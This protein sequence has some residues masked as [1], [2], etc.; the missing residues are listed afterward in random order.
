MKDI[1]EQLVPAL[2]IFLFLTVLLGGAY[3]LLITAI[4]QIGFG[5]QAN[6]SLIKKDG[7]VLGSELI[8]QKFEKPGHFWARPSAVDYNPLPSGG[9]NFG[10]TSQ[11]LVSKVA[12]RKK[13]GMTDD[14]L[15]AS[16]SGLDPHISPKAALAQISRI[17]GAIGVDADKL[18]RLVHEHTEGR[19][20]GVFGEPRVNVF[21]LNLALDE[22]GVYKK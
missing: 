19:Q 9:S 20:L 14:L 8:A 21:K 7:R 13:A 16:G 11:D 15:F 5:H 4:A 12:E 17:S 10:L 1:K 6:G 22:A 18:T 3:P 2:R